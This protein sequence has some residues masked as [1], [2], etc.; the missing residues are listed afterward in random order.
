MP[1]NSVQFA[2]LSIQK[3][4]L[5][6]GVASAIRESNLSF[7]LWQMKNDTLAGSFGFVGTE[8]GFTHRQNNCTHKPFSVL[9]K[10]MQTLPI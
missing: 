8:N 3:N 9:T 2:V 4:V 10:A 6:N 5:S 7:G 1:L